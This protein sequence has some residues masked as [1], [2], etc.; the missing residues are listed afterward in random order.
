MYVWKTLV[1]LSKVDGDFCAQEQSFISEAIGKLPIPDAQKAELSAFAELNEQPSY[2]FEK[3]TEARD[4]GWLFYMARIMFHRDGEF[5]TVEKEI[6]E[7]LKAQ[8][9]STVDLSK[10]K[11]EIEEIKRSF[12]NQNSQDSQPG[13]FRAAL[14]AWLGTLF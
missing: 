5:E 13:G 6:Y 1:S 14:Q 4:R 12:R 7:R 9:M 11:N 3:I 10:V 8:H 2:Y